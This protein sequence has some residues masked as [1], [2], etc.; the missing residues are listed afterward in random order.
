MF[1]DMEWR[2]LPER[3]EPPRK[4]IYD[5]KGAR[6]LGQM[7]GMMTLGSYLLTLGIA[8]HEVSHGDPSFFVACMGGIFFFVP[9][10]AYT[11]TA[12][13]ERTREHSI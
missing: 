10:A 13:Q 5:K 11:L 4:R 9:P 12:V 7:L 2:P 1:V 3:P 8:A 6:K